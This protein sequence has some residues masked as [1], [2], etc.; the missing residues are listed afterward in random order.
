MTTLRRSFFVQPRFGRFVFLTTLLLGASTVCAMAAPAG[1]AKSASPTK[2]SSAKTEK[3][4]EIPKS[5]FEVPTSPK[6]GRDPF[7]PDS[8]RIY[9]VTTTKTNVI[10]SAPP[11]ELVLKILSGTP[12]SPLAAINNHT[13]GVGE[14]ADVLTPAGRVRVRC[15][16]INL[17]DESV[18]I[19]VGGERRELR[20]PRRKLEVR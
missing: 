12:A 20:F 11:A 7:F 10:R 6:E 1:A 14:E 17:S 13:F 15:L 3:S 16:E 5:V 8:T 9:A 19:E 4:V 18:L 2:A